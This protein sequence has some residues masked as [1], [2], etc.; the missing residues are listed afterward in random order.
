MADATSAD[1]VVCSFA[2]PHSK[3]RMEIIPATSIKPYYLRNPRCYQNED[4]ITFWGIQS[5]NL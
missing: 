2:R 3:A 1:V 5:G 4:V